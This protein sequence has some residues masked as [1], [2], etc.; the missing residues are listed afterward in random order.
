MADYF[1]NEEDDSWDN[2]S[3]SSKG[4]TWSQPDFDN[5]EDFQNQEHN[6]SK[7]DAALFALET[8]NETSFEDKGE[9]NNFNG[10]SC[11]SEETK[12]A[13]SKWQPFIPPEH[14]FRNFAAHS[15]PSD[16]S[17]QASSSQEPTL[18]QISTITTQTK[19]TLVPTKQTSPT[20]EMAPSQLKDWHSFK[21]ATRPFTRTWT[22][23][24]TES[25]KTC[26]KTRNLQTEFPDHPEPLKR[27]R[28]WKRQLQCSNKIN[29][30]QNTRLQNTPPVT[31][32]GSEPQVCTQRK[33]RNSSTTKSRTSTTKIKSW[34]TKW[35][36]CSNKIQTCRTNFRK[37]IGHLRK[38]SKRTPLWPWFP[39]RWPP[40][41][42]S[43]LTTE[44][45]D[46]SKQ[47]ILP[48]GRN[49]FSKRRSESE[50]YKNKSENTNSKSEDKDKTARTNKTFQDH[51][52]NVTA[53]ADEVE[54]ISKTKREV[55]ITIGKQLEDGRKFL[56]LTK[57]HLPFLL[58]LYLTTAFTIHILIFN[59]FLF[60]HFHHYFKPLSLRTSGI[61]PFDIHYKN[62]NFTFKMS[63][64]NEATTPHSEVAICTQPLISITRLL[65]N[66][67]N[68]N[69]LVPFSVENKPRKELTRNFWKP[70]FREFCY[71]HLRQLRHHFLLS[72]MFWIQLIGFQTSHLLV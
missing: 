33:S 14:A 45:K 61:A 7:F 11:L 66:T 60:F 24:W 8:I 13:F 29:Q 38:N 36:K 39:R 3:F 67:S 40:T 28:H 56:T 22:K 35:C 20:S 44:I 51:Q 5:S 32:A 54:T 6:P 21:P 17:P 9:T 42:S 30:N 63:T 65:L 68:G 26:N 47:P 50:S 41:C 31:D 25:T 55:R 10:I 4:D 2:K 16:F 46:H 23:P 19:R 48:R 34:E 71:S 57:P 72:F 53:K 59:G 70:P 27:S 69:S 49:H 52:H 37:P 62:H 12:L 18:I 43:G 58:H 15:W 1:S 64:A